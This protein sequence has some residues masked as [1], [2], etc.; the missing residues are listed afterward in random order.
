MHGG[1]RSGRR[2]YL[3][4]VDWRHL[5]RE[6]WSEGGEGFP[7]D[8]PAVR[9]LEM[10]LALDSEVTFLVGEN[11]SGKSTIME[12]LAAKVELD[13]EGG[14]REMTFVA[15]NVDTSLVERLRV[16]RGVRRPSMS[17]FLRAES[18]FNVAREV[19]RHPGAL[20][21]HGGTPLH[22]MSHGE[23]FLALVMHRLRP[24]GLYLFDE[25]EAALS[26]QGCLTLLR[27]IRQLAFEGSQFVI[28][29]HSPILM[30]YPEATIYELS[31]RGIDRVVYDEV[32]HVQL[33]RSF[34][35]DPEQFLRQLFH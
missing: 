30:A 18:F 28:A 7:F 27:G 4:C 9:A 33:T 11:G 19:D 34:L 26:P 31:E 2:R 20:G 15:R 32:S 8:L 17:Y 23:S 21:A 16:A 13:A 29:T 22:G 12:A 14:D 10:P 25:P 24:D 3:R 1:V 35:E 6:V 5:I